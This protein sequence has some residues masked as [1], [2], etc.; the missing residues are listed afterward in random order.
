[1]C[2][3]I[4]I[5]KTPE[6]PSSS[7]PVSSTSTKVA[8]MHAQFCHHRLVLDQHTF[9]NWHTSNKRQ[10]QNCKQNHTWLLSTLEGFWRISGVCVEDIKLNRR[11]LHKGKVLYLCF[12][13][14]CT[15]AK[16]DTFLPMSS[17]YCD[18]ICIIIWMSLFRN[19]LYNLNT[20][21]FFFIPFC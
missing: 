10:V 19:T 2:I 7:F 16:I 18:N 5:P 20:S 14:S 4:N 17:N 6:A 21:I 13:K 8:C 3:Y 11:V 9:C 12:L 1:M 15:K